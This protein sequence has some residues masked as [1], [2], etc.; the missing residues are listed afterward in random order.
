MRSPILCC[1][2]V[3]VLLLPLMLGCG[4]YPFSGSG[5]KEIRNTLGVRLASYGK[6]QDAAW[7]HL[8][9]IGVHSIFINVPKPDEVDATVEKLQAHGLKTPVMRGDTDLSKDTC[10]ADLAV[11]LET[12]EKMGAK[13]MFLSPK[14]HDAPKEVIFERLRQA[15]DV[16]RKHGVI[17]ALET[18]PD[19]GTN[20]DVHLDTMRQIHHPNIRVNFDT[21]NIHYYN[22]GTDAP[23]ELKKII[24][25]VATVE[26]KD[27][28]GEFET[29]NFPALGRGV[30]KIPETVC[31]LQDHNYPGPITIEVEG[32]QGVEWSEKETKEYIAESVAYMRTL[33]QF[34]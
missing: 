7:D 24:D 4:T 27:H 1:F 25:Y 29:W 33:G 8:E 6:Y 21:G 13:Y 17:I 15:G 20:G 16:A 34:D 26:F 19:L 14:R 12:C 31:I 22:K 32:I 11:Q 2:L 10:I 9:S 18:H 23:T 30:V 28:N 3:S 5:E